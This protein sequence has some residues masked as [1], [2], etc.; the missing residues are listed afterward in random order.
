MKLS[1]KF[2]ISIIATVFLVSSLLIVLAWKVNHDLSQTQ[3]V[4]SQLITVKKGES[5]YSL[6]NELAQK[7][8]IT[9]VWQIKLLSKLNPDLTQIRAGTFLLEGQLSN[10]DVVK[11]FTQ[12]QPHQFKMT[13]PEG[14]NLTQW[15]K[16]LTEHE[17]LKQ[18]DY[19]EKLNQLIAPHQHA[20]GLLFPDTYYFT[21]NSDD[22]SLIEAAFKRMQQTRQQLASALTD[23]QWYNTLILASI[24]EKETAVVSEMPK[25]ASVFYNRLNKNMRLQTDPTVIYG[26]GERYQGDIKRVHLNEKNPYNTYHIKGLPPTP[27]AMPGLKAIEAVIE[28]ANTDYYY[29]VADG[30]GGHVFTTNLKAHNQAVQRY[31][32][33]SKSSAESNN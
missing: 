24:V 27:I 3:L 4:E 22:F 18:T 15:Q 19:R 2:L 14:I 20:E 7:N 1:F 28:P 5:L 9:T 29:F 31:L 30:K 16:K 6:L 23:E 33:L 11:V 13:F 26:L 10:I 12:G 17:W 21:A 32:S 8:I 25:V